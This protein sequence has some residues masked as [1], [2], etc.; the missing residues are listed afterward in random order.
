[1]RRL[2]LDNG[3]RVVLDARGDA[4]AVGVAVHYGTGFRGDPVGRSG[5]AHLFEH[6]MFQGSG[7]V[8]PGEH[9]SVVQGSGGTAGGST[10]QDHTDFYQ[11][12]PTAAL[13]RLLFL[14]ADRMA[15]L[16]L[17]EEGLRA[18]LRVIREEIRTQVTGR[19]YGGFP[20]TVLPGVL[21]TSYANG[22]N[23]YGDVEGLHDVTPAECAAF[24]ETHYAP[25]RAVLTVC[26]GFDETEAAELVRRHFGPLP[27][28]PEAGPVSLAEP[29]PAGTRTGT[30]EDGHA[31]LPAL[32][33]GH[34]MPDPARRLPAYV[35]HMVLSAL[36]TGTARGLLT[37]RL[38]ATTGLAVAVRSAC[39]FFGPLQA[40]DPDTFHVVV[41]RRPE[42]APEDVLS[43]TDDVLRL[44]ARQGPTPGELERTRA[45]IRVSLARGYDSLLQRTRHTGAF[46]L[47]H[48]RAGLADDLPRL[49]AATGPDDV[50]AAAR[51]LLSTPRAVLGLRTTREAAPA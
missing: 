43:E 47:L 27:P 30:R 4:P 16:R 32:A 15:G 48:D 36:L 12:A 34:R 51:S 25:S 2:T 50:A 22:H 3:L 10:H 11:V 29:P 46:T 45:Q 21:Y 31:P 44:L 26:G 20:W 33:L 49:V 19:P 41:T 24:H 9:F 17:T 35:A 1:M 5:F 42:S 38:V 23:G 39:G 40:R 6:L 37:H 18:Q 28:R 8:A 7:R 13:E 14:E